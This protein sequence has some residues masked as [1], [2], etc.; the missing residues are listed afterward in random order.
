MDFFQEH[1]EGPRNSLLVEPS[2]NVWIYSLEL[3]VPQYAIWYSYIITVPLVFLYEY[4]QTPWIFSFSSPHYPMVLSRSTLV[5][6]GTARTGDPDL[7]PRPGYEKMLETTSFHGFL[8]FIFIPFQIWCYIQLYSVIFPILSI[9]HSMD[10]GFKGTSTG[11][12]SFFF[13]PKRDFPLN[14]FMGYEPSGW[15]PLRWV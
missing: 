1:P 4:P 15:Q 7:T 3:D 13:T 11:Y 6:L 2:A 8:N 12:H 10:D 14:Q 5:Q 9:L